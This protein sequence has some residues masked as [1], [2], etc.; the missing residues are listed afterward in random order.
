MVGYR[1]ILALSVLAAVSLQIAAQ[2]TSLSGTSVAVSGSSLE[3]YPSLDLINSFTGVVPGVHQTENYGRTGVRYNAM[4]A[5]LKLRGFSNPIFIVDGVVIRDETELQINPEEIDSVFVVSDILDK[6]KY[7]PEAAQGAIYIRTSRGER[8]SR[9][10]RFGFDSGVDVVDRFPEWVSD[11][12]GYAA[13]NNMARLNAGYPAKYTDFAMK[14][15][16]ARNPLDV[17]FPSV[18]YRSLMFRNVREYNKAFAQIRGGSNM[19]TYSADIGF[20]EQ[21]DIFKV[22]SKS[23]YNRFNAKMNIDIRINDRLRVDFNFIGIYG[24]RKTPLGLY[25]ATGNTSEFASV[26]SRAISTPPSAYPLNLGVDEASGKVIYPVSTAYPD[27]PYG[28]LAE[29]GYYKESTRTGITDLT[30]HYDLSFLLPG[31]RSESQ[32]GYN[33]LYMV[34]TGK[35]TDYIG[36]NMDSDSWSSTSSTHKGQS[37]SEES[38]FKTFYLQGLQ[39][40]ESLRYDRDFG[41]HGV[42]AGLTY[43]LSR[44][45]GSLYSG[46]HNQQFLSLD[47][48]YS[49][50]GRYGF[51]FIVNLAGS[52]SLAPGHRYA[53]FPAFGLSWNVSKEPWMQNVGWIDLLRVRAQAGC[54]GNEQYGDQFYWQSRYTKSAEMTFG[55]YSIG[56][57]FGS[58]T[59]TTKAANIVRAANYDLDWERIHECTAGID[60]T[61]FHCLDF[62][63]T[64]YNTIRGG[65]VTDISSVLPM[66]NGVTTKYGNYNSF[67]YSGVDLRLGVRGK[68]GD[69]SYEV[70]ASA[71]FPSSKVRRYCEVPANEYLDREGR[72]ATAIFGYDCIGRFTS[73]SD[74]SGSPV[75]TF[76]SEVCVGDL[77]YRDITGD[78]V[79]DTNDRMVIGDSAPKML[80]SLNLSLAYRGFDLFLVCTG[81]A[82]VDAQL[83]NAYYWNGWGDGNYSAFV[84]D[85]L[86]T[87][88]YP[89]LSYLQSQNNFRTSR[90][91]IV[92]GSFFKLQCVELGYN[93]PRIRIFVKGANL[94]TISGIK[95]CDPESLSSG[96]SDYPL[97]RTFTGGLKFTF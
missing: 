22:G 8:D 43:Y 79:V 59:F 35:G 80:Y 78:G 4:N 53:V 68:A 16:E 25:G 27:H 26:Y 86:T 33:I 63:L 23:N 17:A 21:G 48:R 51:E 82:F 46:Y 49:Y 29:S 62:G 54:S 7:G 85:N 40:K 69:F 45:V 83:T 91:W 47:G 41:K 24:I 11:G 67:R 38:T 50:D 88:R 64:Y 39:F 14:R 13:M 32:V 19:V 31:L 6:L 20:T 61:L 84:R 42:G 97:F 65:V 77:K 15:L 76:D 58:N 36:Y 73:A 1:K 74:I 2:E 56:Q 12:A 92:D 9:T 60:A 81:K 44:E 70:G 37:D 18:D 30:L 93:F 66:A 72:S 5:S 89:R 95:D 90:Y 52:T 71:L 96:V 28:S 94:F 10:I 75:Q 55:A 3:H 87:G 57:W 34:R